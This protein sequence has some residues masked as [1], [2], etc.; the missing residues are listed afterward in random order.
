MHIN[1]NSLCNLFCLL[2]TF[3]TLTIS[4]SAIPVETTPTSSDETRFDETSFDKASFGKTDETNTTSI[5]TSKPDTKKTSTKT[6]SSM[7]QATEQPDPDYK[8][9]QLTQA[10]RWIHNK[11]TKPNDSLLLKALKLPLEIG[12]AVLSPINWALNKTL[13]KINPFVFRQTSRTIH[14]LLNS[15]TQVLFPEEFQLIVQPMA[16]SMTVN[17]SRFLLEKAEPPIIKKLE[18]IIINGFLGKLLSIKTTDLQKLNPNLKKQVLVYRILERFKD[19]LPANMS[20]EKAYQLFAKGERCIDN[21]RFIFDLADNLSSAASLMYQ[22]TQDYQTTEQI[23]DPMEALLITSESKLNKCIMIIE[24]LSRCADSYIKTIDHF[25]M[26]SLN[27][28][29]LATLKINLQHFVSVTQK[30]Y[31][32]RKFI[33]P[34]WLLISNLREESKTKTEIQKFLT[35]HYKMK[36]EDAKNLILAEEKD[37][38]EQAETILK[39]YKLNPQRVQRDL[40][41]AFAAA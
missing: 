9:S 30:I 31:P 41:R 27:Q 22:L 37:D 35:K 7:Q 25:H 5:P 38:I 28:G 10:L 8:P 1:T 6:S 21:L 24:I 16:P 14:K 29:E 3:T 23:E 39:K 32:F 33:V 13:N 36:K 26:T 34:A 12:S 19:K 11:K 40:D 4:I 17:A 2:I 20:V 15:A 18:K